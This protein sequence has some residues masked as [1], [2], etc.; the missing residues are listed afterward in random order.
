MILFILSKCS[1]FLIYDVNLDCRKRNIVDLQLHIA[2]LPRKHTKGGDQII[3]PYKPILVASSFS[4]F[5]TSPKNQDSAFLCNGHAHR[6][7]LT[8]KT[9]YSNILREDKCTSMY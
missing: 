2:A 5:L 7:T 6:D 3:D 1:V 4:I 8:F 9:D